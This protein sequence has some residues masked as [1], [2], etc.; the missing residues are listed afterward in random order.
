MAIPA[1]PVILL[2]GTDFGLDATAHL[3]SKGAAGDCHR[4]HPHRRKRHLRGGQ[5]QL[6]SGV[7]LSAVCSKKDSTVTTLRVEGV[8]PS[9]ASILV[10]SGV[11]DQYYGEFTSGRFRGLVRSIRRV[12]DSD[13]RTRKLRALWSVL[14]KQRPEFRSI[15]VVRFYETVYSN[16]PDRE[17]PILSFRNHS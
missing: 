7:R 2:A 16:D 10:L 3:R 12:R 17:R 11:Q 14:R 1:L 13:K 8:D 5:D 4:D 6:V 15:E 9:G